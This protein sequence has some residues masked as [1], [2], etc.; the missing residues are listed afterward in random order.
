MKRA[1]R[2]AV[3]AGVLLGA[4]CEGRAEA[5]DPVASSVGPDM[6]VLK[7][8]SMMR[9]TLTEMI[10]NDHATLLLSSGQSARIRW[11]AIQRI[12]KTNDAPAIAVG[13][14]PTEPQATPPKVDASVVVHIDAARPVELEATEEG[15]NR[16]AVWT[17]V[18]VS[19][20]DKSLPTNRLYRI[21]GEGVRSSRAVSF[22]GEPEGSHVYLN[23]NVGTK[24]GFVGGIVL[25]S[26]G[27]A[28]AAVGATLVLLSQND[29]RYALATTTRTTNKDLL[30]GGLITMGAG[31]AMLIPGIILTVKHAS[32]RVVVSNA[33][34]RT[35]AKGE[36]LDAF[37]R[38]PVWNAPAIASSP[39]MVGTP[40]LSGT[41]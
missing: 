20:C 25:T 19:P 41:F 5:A 10:K 23:A 32:T 39:A 33:A 27:T 30:A 26:I 37:R 24:G 14:A 34:P 12:E 18:C 2:A 38:D 21:A 17:S 28:A 22:R 9:G 15:D 13:P 11:D 1:I 36:L 29:G 3:A 16:H 6:V 4:V 31:V 40:L 8:G 35:S 7:D